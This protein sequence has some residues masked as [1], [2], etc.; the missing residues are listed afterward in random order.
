MSSVLIGASVLPTPAAGDPRHPPAPDRQ[1]APQTSDGIPGEIA[2]W[3]PRTRRGPESWTWT[4]LAGWEVVPGVSFE[5]F[6]LS[7]PRGP[8]RGHLLRISY[9]ATG[10]SLDYAGRPQ[11]ASTAPLLDTVLADQAIAGVNGDFFDIGDTGAPLG[12][13]RDRQ[14]KMLHGVASGW[15]CAFFIKR[16][17]QPDIDFLYASG[18]IVQRP[19]IEIPTVNTPSVRQGG[20]GLYTDK[21]G[22]LKGYRVTDGQKQK[23]RMVVVKDG[24]V[25]ENRKTFPKSMKVQGK[26][27][28][29]RDEGARQL[30]A[31]KKG[32]QLTI[33]SRLDPR[34]KVAITGNVFLIRDGERKARDDREMHPRTA[35][36]ID[37]DTQVIFLLVIDGRQDLSRGYTMVEMATLMEYLGADEALNLD[38]GGS[39]TM[40]AQRPN[41]KVKV[42]NNPSDGRQRS[43]P[44]GLEVLYDPT[45]TPPPPPEP[46]LPPEPP[47][48][49]AS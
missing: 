37:Y 34:P 11:I 4:T 20:V 7:D 40:V 42:L 3:V 41:G 35:I 6:D 48:P 28:I 39:S 30:R 9:N 26:V 45:A 31:L 23:V 49:P 21:W 47:V 15:N 25:T 33:K 36:G 12:V 43:V 8:V 24:V 1:R 44:N 17:G 27:L 46:P 19:E 38:G 2:P 32:T 10:I 14:R 29:G 13:G 22:E 16:D 5:K 18:R